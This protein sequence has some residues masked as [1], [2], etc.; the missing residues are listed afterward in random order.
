MGEMSSIKKVAQNNN[1]PTYNP[2]QSKAIQTRNKD[3]LVSAGAGCGKTFVM[4]ERIAQNIIERIASVDRLLVVTYTNAAASEMRVKLANKINELLASTQY[5]ESEKSYLREQADLIGQSDICTVHKFCQN[6]IEKYFYVLDIDPNFD[7]CDDTE[8]FSLKRRA[9]EQIFEE[10]IAEKDANFELLRNTFDDKRGFDKISNYV[11]KIYTFLNNQPDISAFKNKVR[12]AFDIDLDKNKFAQVINKNVVETIEHFRNIFLDFKREAMALG[13]NGIYAMLE[14]LCFQMSNIHSLNTF[15]Q[16]LMLVFALNVPR[17]SNSPAKSPEESD[18]RSRLGTAKKDFTSAL[19]ELRKNFVSS[20]IEVIQQ[21]MLASQQIVNAMLE[22]VEKFR[23]RYLKLKK[24]KNLLDFSDLEHFAYQILS[25]PKVNTEVRSHYQ[26]IYVDEYQDV[27]DIQEGI[28]NKVH[29]VRDIFLVGDV[30]QSIYGFRNTNPQIFLDKYDSF[31]AEDAQSGSAVTINLNNNYRSDQRVLDYVNWLFDIL[32]TRDFAGIDYSKGNAMNSASDYQHN[33]ALALP[34][35]EFMIVNP[36]KQIEEKLDASEVYRVSTAPQVQDDEISFAR[37]EAYAIYDKIMYLLGTQ[38]TIYDAKKKIDREIQF[39]DITILARSRSK[40]L[41]EIRNTLL[42]LGLPVAPIG[43]ENVLEE[44][45]VKLLFDYLN[46]LDNQ[47]DDIALTEFLVSPIIGLNEEELCKI[48]SNSPRAEFFYQCVPNYTDN[49]KIGQKI[50]FARSLINKSRRG[51]VNNTVYQVLMDFCNTTDYLN[52]IRAMP[53]GESKVR[54]VMGFAN[55]FIGKSYNY[56]LRDYLKNTAQ[57]VFSGEILSEPNIEASVIGVATMH[58]SKGLE[59]PIVFMVDCGH[60]YNKDDKKGDF[61][62]NSDL[63]IG[64]YVYDREKRIKKKTILY[65]A[66]KIATKDKDLAERERLIYVAMTR[67]KNHLF[68]SGVLELKNFVP[69][70]TAFALKSVKNDLELIL[71]S[72]SIDQIETLKSLK[73]LTQV[74]NNNKVEYHVITPPEN[75]DDISLEKTQKTLKQHTDPR[76]E[77]ILT[78]NLEFL[79]PYR[80]CTTL[81]LNNSVTAL[82]NLGNFNS[83]EGDEGLCRE[84]MSEHDNVDTQVGI[85]FHKAMQIIDFNL[86]SEEDVEQFLKEKMASDELNLINCGKIFQAICALRPIISGAKILREQEFMMKVPLNELVETRVTDSVLV[87]GIIDLLIIKD[88]QIIIIDYKTTNSKN[89]EKTA[90][91]Y[92]TQLRCYQ[93]AVEEIY[94]RPVK[95]KF[96]YFFLQERLILIDNDC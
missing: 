30:K 91:K 58:Q 34:S 39:S 54:N 2:E 67:A 52:I 61:L 10:L 87:Q 11:Y 89:L 28:L 62:L 86:K 72:L 78:Q 12:G 63:G 43:K 15:A 76:Y 4:I 49:D 77:A 84:T 96:L 13:L 32:M 1:G 95:Q 48:R 37:A 92:L 40:A 18:L 55:S 88:D 94:F 45:E 9:L 64:M 17:L 79:Y 8:A 25:D 60:Q 23:K 6:I 41:V 16:N 5:D 35:V 42:S 19:Q 73:S 65:S 57:G 31:G 66:V 33:N 3:I 53:N 75:E 14:I 38:K 93:K 90:K 71:S 59:Y 47:T 46:L 36:V 26:Q 56:D 27:N 74:I 24:A 44:Y 70:Q 21:D 81:A 50:E 85:A 69:Y 82:N 7:I 20:D 29:D 22:L 80:E 51:L 83:Q 68:V